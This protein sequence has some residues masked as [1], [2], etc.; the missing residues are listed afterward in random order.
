V[1][2]LAQEPVIPAGRTTVIRE[3]LE[4]LWDLAEPGGSGEGIPGT[5]DR[6]QLMPHDP[7]CHVL[8]WNPPLCTCW[9]RSIVEL[10]RLLYRMQFEAPTLFRHLRYRYLQCEHVTKTASYQAGR[11]HGISVNE[12]V[13][14]VPGG[15]ALTLAD[16]RH[17]RSNKPLE[18]RV[19]VARWR[20]DTNL[21]HANNAITW[22]AAEWALNHE[23]N[24]PVV[25]AA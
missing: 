17:K 20:D 21:T 11:W 18:A 9:R 24:L 2:A 10:E 8:D 15:W 1:T 22:L 6:V 7:R 16:Q 19:K 23:P 3:L 12:Q 5:G 4:R 13:V 14:S 25:K